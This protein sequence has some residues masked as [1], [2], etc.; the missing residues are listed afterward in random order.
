MTSVNNDENTDTSAETRHSRTAITGFLPKGEQ[1]VGYHNTCLS[2][3]HTCPSREK[4]SLSYALDP[5]IEL[6]RKQSVFTH[7]RRTRTAMMGKASARVTKRSRKRHVFWDEL[8]ALRSEKDTY[9]GILHFLYHQMLGGS[10]V[11]S[12]L[13]LIGCLL[14][15]SSTLFFLVICSLCRTSEQKA[16]SV[17]KSRELSVSAGFVSDTPQQLPGPIAQIRLL[18]LFHYSSVLFG[19]F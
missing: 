7:K 19:N 10:P 13:G 9:F 14:D 3:H 4:I 12:H 2:S 8:E 6:A 1:H 17:G 15:I 5:L 18:P 11:V 16:P